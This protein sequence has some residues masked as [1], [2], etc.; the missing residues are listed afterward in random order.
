[1]MFMVVQK[2]AKV[3]TNE[4]T[5]SSSYSHSQK[6]VVFPLGVAAPFCSGGIARSAAQPLDR[7]IQGEQSSTCRSL[8]ANTLK[9]GTTQKQDWFAVL[10]AK[11][12]N[13]TNL[14]GKG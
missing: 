12:P 7:Q 9:R 1:M 13:K 8:Q 4:P 5:Y 3:A 2:A 14:L 6:Q 11:V 10:T